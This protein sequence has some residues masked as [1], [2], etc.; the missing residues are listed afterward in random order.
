MTTKPQAE[1]I[2]KCATHT[3]ICTRSMSLDHSAASR[4]AIIVVHWSWWCRWC[5]ITQASRT[6]C[7]I[8]ESTSTSGW[9]CL[10]LV[11]DRTTKYHS[12]LTLGSLGRRLLLLLAVGI[13]FS[14][15]WL[16]CCW[17]GASTLGLGFLIVI[18]TVAFDFYIFLGIRSL[19]AGDVCNISLSVEVQYG[20]IFIQS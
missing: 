16:L 13:A 1:F 3:L 17:L 11:Y 2:A 20:G 12:R 10:L 9:I 5:R 7:W 4:L 15:R 8:G 18:G 6:T 19:N 14:G